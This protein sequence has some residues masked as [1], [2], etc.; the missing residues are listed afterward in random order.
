MAVQWSINPNKS[1]ALTYLATTE[2]ILQKKVA[3]T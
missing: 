1:L 2:L 3:A